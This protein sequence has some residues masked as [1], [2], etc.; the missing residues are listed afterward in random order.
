MQRS[1]ITI[2]AAVVGFLFFASPRVFDPHADAAGFKSIFNGKDLT[3]WEGD[4]KYW[5]VVDGAITGTTDGKM[6]YN[7]FLIWRA[8]T[9][10]NFEL[11]CEVRMEGGNSGIQYRSRQL[12]DVGEFVMA[13][14]QCD[15]VSDRPDY[16]GML[17]EERGRGLLAH[18]FEK[19]IID[20]KGNKW[21][22]GHLPEAPPVDVSK[23]HEFHLTVKG[24]H[25][26]HKVNGKVT[27]D[28]TDFQD[29][30]RAL[31]GL[32]G[33]QVHAGPPMR[34]QF[35]NIRIRELPDSPLIKFKDSMVPAGAEKVLPPGPPKQK[36]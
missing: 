18:T 36:K 34:V 35:R 24:N 22:I 12:P 3:G 26:V 15:M 31:S 21:V 10:R 33:F 16:H 1:I 27:A 6:T 25:H 30:K 13:G 29:E 2:C 23:W 17:Y 7:R 4:P 9:L 14:Y 32:L 11:I 5:S 28:V 20:P 8:G 19:T